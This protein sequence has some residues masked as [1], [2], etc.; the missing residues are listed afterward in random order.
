MSKSKKPF[1]YNRVVVK[2]SGEACGGKSGSGINLKV[3]RKIARDIAKVHRSGVQVAVVLGGGNLWRG[4]EAAQAGMDRVQADKIGM[5]ATV[6]NG[7]ALQDILEQMGC[8]TRTMTAVEIP[9]MAE[10]YIQRRAIRHLEKGR[11]V[12][13]VGGIGNPMFSTDTTVVQRAIEIDANIG[14]VGKNGTDGVYTGPPKTDP[15]ARKLDNVSLE[16]ALI[17]GYEVMDSTA[18]AQANAHKLTLVIYDGNKAGE[19]L[20]VLRGV[21]RVG[22]IVHP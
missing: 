6:M 3:M 10:P 5:L 20:R 17:K 14:A 7:L 13:F 4:A 19:L 12:I 11:I 16:D 8:Q 1:K 22:T 15:S 2:I 9:S 21:K 18:F